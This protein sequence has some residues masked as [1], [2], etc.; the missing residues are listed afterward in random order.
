MFLTITKKI[1]YDKIK[2]V[3]RRL[4]AIEVLTRFSSKIITVVFTKGTEV[5]IL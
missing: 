4:C 5:F 2:L 3:L 1:S